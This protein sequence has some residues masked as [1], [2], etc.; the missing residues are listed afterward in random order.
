MIKE[1]LTLVEAGEKWGISVNTVKSRLL[2]NP[3]QLQ[4]EYHYRK[5]G[6]VW[7]ITV[8]GMK[9]LYGEPGAREE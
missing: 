5:S 3:P 4:K 9:I 6:K 2:H 8:E 1:V 7:L